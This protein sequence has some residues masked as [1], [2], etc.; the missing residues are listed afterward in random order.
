MSS[1]SV[2]RRVEGRPWP[3]R[4]LVRCEMMRRCL[5]PKTRTEVGGRR[6]EAGTQ[7]SACDEADVACPVLSC[8][9]LWS[10]RT[11]QKH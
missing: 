7:P 2:S 3:W 4:L 10:A 8:P 5:D 6:G 1:V 9:V 11:G